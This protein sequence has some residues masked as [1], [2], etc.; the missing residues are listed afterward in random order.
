MR[1]YPK[2]H[3]RCTCLHRT[4]HKKRS[5][6]KVAVYY[7]DVQQGKD[8]KKLLFTVSALSLTMHPQALGEINDFGQQG[9]WTL[10]IGHIFDY[11]PY[12]GTKFPD[13]TTI[14]YFAYDWENAHLGIDGFNYTFYKK[15]IIEISLLVEPRWSFTDPEDSLSF[16]NIERD[17]ALEAGLSAQINTRGF[18]LSSE[19]LHDVSGTHKGLEASAEIGFS[20]DFGPLE[21]SIGTGIVFRD[22]A[23]SQHL[24]GVNDNE[25]QTGLVAYQAPANSHQYITADVFFSLGESSGIAL[26]GRYEKLT[27]EIT[28]SPLI[29]RTKDANVG[30]FFI[31]QF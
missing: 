17:I 3:I 26:F 16:T 18:Y 28:N 2:G 19:F 14:P 4:T 9:G 8:M 21:W 24:F 22:Q 6:G 10:G 7:I 31:S 27:R 29:S 13:G 25:V 11:S 1:A 20:K 30:I 12:T 23:L 15:Q 5:L